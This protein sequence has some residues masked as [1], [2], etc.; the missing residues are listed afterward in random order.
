MAKLDDLKTHLQAGQTYR[1]AELSQWSKAID[2]HLAQLVKERTLEKLSGGV[3]YCPKKTTFGDA[4]PDDQML[5]RTFLKDDRFL[6]LTPNSYNALGV[7][8]TQLYSYTVV[9]NHKRH[10]KFKLGGR[11]FDFRMKPHFPKKPSAEFLL[12]DLVNNIKQ[13]AEDTD[14]V[15]NA[16]FKKAQSYDL[17]VLSKAVRHYGSSRAQKHFAE[18]LSDESL[19]YGT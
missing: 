2:R 13:L 3:Y 15:L 4:P 7:A 16:A 12:V 9:Y 11:V 5:V 17:K 14:S 18:T 19:K 8:T 6:L 10:G 1:R